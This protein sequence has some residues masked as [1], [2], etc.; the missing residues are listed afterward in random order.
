MTVLENILIGFDAQA[1]YSYFEAILRLPRYFIYEKRIRQ[2]AYE[3]ME[4][5]GISE[6]A[7]MNATALSYGNQRKVE[8]ARALSYKS[9]T[10][11]TR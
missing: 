11:T 7:D 9:K 6:F 3:L 1:K 5:F 4:I 2:K 8:I 10:S